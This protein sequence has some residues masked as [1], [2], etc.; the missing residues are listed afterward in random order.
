MNAFCTI[1]LV[2]QN[3]VIW[4]ACLDLNFPLFLHKVTG[5]LTGT[6]QLR[7]GQL[8]YCNVGLTQQHSY[9]VHSF[10]S[11]QRLVKCSSLT[12]YLRAITSLFRSLPTMRHVTIQMHC[13]TTASECIATFPA[14]QSPISSGTDACHSTVASDSAV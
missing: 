12:C 10:S 7:L 11:F 5:Q 14:H 6:G 9:N 4:A 8:P 3:L 1:Q 2:V 13:S